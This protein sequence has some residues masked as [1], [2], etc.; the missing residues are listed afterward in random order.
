MVEEELHSAP[1]RTSE[2]KKNI[3]SILQRMNASDDVEDHD[4]QED[5]LSSKLGELDISE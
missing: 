3:I 5:D 2:E 1:G 4:E